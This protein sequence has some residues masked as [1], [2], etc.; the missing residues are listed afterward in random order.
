MPQV[1]QSTCEPF[2]NEER[3][4]DAAEKLDDMSIIAA[5]DQARKWIQWW[6]DAGSY[7][8]SYGR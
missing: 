3:A 1:N 8:A 5:I 7:L 2:G 6:C 4:L